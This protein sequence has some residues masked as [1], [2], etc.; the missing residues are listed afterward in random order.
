MMQ[1]SALLF[2]VLVTLGRSA[3]AQSER[4]PPE[5]FI[6]LTSQTSVTLEWPAISPKFQVEL[7]EDDRLLGS[8]Q[9]QNTR[10]AVPI[11]HGGRY[12]WSVTPAAGAPMVGHFS[13][14][15]W[16]EYNADGADDY[17][18]NGKK[19]AIRLERAE[20]GMQMFLQCEAD[21]KKFIFLTRERLFVV[22]ARGGSGAAHPAAFYDANDPKTRVKRRKSGSGGFGG[23]VEISTR[24]TL[25]REYLKVD[26]RGGRGGFGDAETEGRPGR[27]GK[28]ITKILP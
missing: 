28:I 9:V 7:Y 18:T 25:W 19:I 3:P 4:F 21:R 2:G 16:W 20:H 26:V 1:K 13:V 14:S 6:L 5:G 11:R 10:L 24:D 17:G 12:R 15:D 8:Y 22:T 27:P 23:L